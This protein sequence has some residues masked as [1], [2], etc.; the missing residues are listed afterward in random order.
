MPMVMPTHITSD[1]SDG[2]LCK[3]LTENGL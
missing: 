1:V 3:I 2:L